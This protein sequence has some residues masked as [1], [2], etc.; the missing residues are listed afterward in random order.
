M[1]RFA[2][3]LACPHEG[4]GHNSKLFRDGAEGEL[5][6]PAHEHADGTRCKEH[7]HRFP[8]LGGQ[9]MRGWDK[10]PDCKKDAPRYPDAEGDP[11]F[12][13][14]VCLC[15]CDQQMKRKA[16]EAP[17]LSGSMDGVTIKIS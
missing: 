11:D 15:G 2:G 6:C 3:Y 13:R 1:A 14:V 5:R 7:K 10:C 17:P 12:E 4:C 9:G 8:V 16:P